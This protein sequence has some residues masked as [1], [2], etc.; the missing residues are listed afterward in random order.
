MVHATVM[1]GAC[2]QFS[3]RTVEPVSVQAFLVQPFSAL[4][5]F[6]GERPLSACGFASGGIPSN[7]LPAKKTLVGVF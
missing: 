4:D 7:A 2:L 6:F 5:T 1:N 3:N